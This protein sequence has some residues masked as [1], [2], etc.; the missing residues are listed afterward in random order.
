MAFGGASVLRALAPSQVRGVPRSPDGGIIAD[1][2]GPVDDPAALA[3]RF[4]ATP[5]VIE[6]GLF[7]PEMVS[8]IL[9]GHADGSVERRI[10]G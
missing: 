9:I 3:G 10:A 5:G 8:E 6:H 7:P 1:Y 2:M 4:D